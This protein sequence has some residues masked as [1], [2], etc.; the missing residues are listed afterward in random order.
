MRNHA[1]DELHFDL[2]RADAANLFVM[3]LASSI[4][5]LHFSQLINITLKC[6]A[7]S[8]DSYV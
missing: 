7:G 6:A 5:L 2:M 3:M 4:L 1:L 8:L